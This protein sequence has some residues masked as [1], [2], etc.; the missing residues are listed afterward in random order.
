ML[1]ELVADGARVL[2]LEVVVVRAEAVADLVRERD[3]A[4]RLRLRL[5]LVLH[6]RNATRFYHYSCSSCSLTCLV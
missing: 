3:L 5:A 6:T 1:L 4:H 2:R